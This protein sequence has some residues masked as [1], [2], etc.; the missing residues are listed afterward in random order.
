M[1]ATKRIG[2]AATERDRRA[3]RLSRRALGTAGIM[4]A[5][6]VTGISSAGASTGLVGVDPATV[7]QGELAL[8]SQVGTPFS[9]E[10]G[11]KEHVFRQGAE[12]TVEHDQFP[13]GTTSG[14]H[15]H[16]GPVFVTVVSGAL[17]LYEAKDEKCKGKTYVA[18]TGFLEPG[19]GDVHDARNEGLV[20]VDIYATY[21]LPRGS[22][23]NGIFIPKPDF[24]NLDC[25]FAN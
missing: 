2:R 12:V 4:V 25:P 19:F 3:G 23:D 20:P 16:S 10:I 7:P 1:L 15:A 5:V 11:G 6:L 13:V 18:G 9:L 14:W 21:L 22:G 17:T 24:S 8:E